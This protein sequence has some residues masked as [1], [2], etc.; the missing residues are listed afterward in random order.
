M[1]LCACDNEDRE[2]GDD[3]ELVLLDLCSG[4]LHLHT[5]ANINGTNIELHV[6]MQLKRLKVDST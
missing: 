4:R 3:R 6:K 2:H 5:L 1:N